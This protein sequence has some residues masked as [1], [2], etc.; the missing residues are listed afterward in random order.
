MEWAKKPITY[1]LLQITR[2]QSEPIQFGVPLLAIT[3][4]MFCQIDECK[5]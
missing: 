5:I 1:P 3:L 2:N 4:T